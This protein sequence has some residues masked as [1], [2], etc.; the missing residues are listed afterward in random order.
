MESN[1]YIPLKGDSNSFFERLSNY[2]KGFDANW[3]KMRV[4]YWKVSL[5]NARDVEGMD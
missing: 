5:P 3:E 2:V 4:V 1:I